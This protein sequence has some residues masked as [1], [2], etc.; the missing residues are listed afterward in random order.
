M[1][2]SMKTLAVLTLAM[3]LLLTGCDALDYRDAIALYNA[4]EFSQAADRFAQIPDYED[5]AQLYTRAR[6]WQALELY[7]AGQFT[8][9]AEVFAPL[10][11]YED[12][13]QLH[14]RCYYNLAVQTM[15]AGDYTDA[16][17]Q[18]ESL[19]GFEDVVQRIAECQ[20]Q[21]AIVAFQAEDLPAAQDQFSALGDYRM[22][23]DYLRQIGW[24]RFFDWMVSAGEADGA[25]YT[26][27]T[28]EDGRTVSVTADTDAPNRLILKIEQSVDKGYT[29][30]DTLTIVLPREEA[31]PTFTGVSTFTMML[32]AEPI[33]TTQESIGRLELATC[34]AD[35]KLS[36]ESYIKTGTDNQGNAISS[37]TPGD[38]TMYD[39]MNENFQVLM[40]TLP[41]LL[42]AH[43]APVSLAD[44]GF[45]Q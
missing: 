5:S 2:R 43:N 6:Y 20:Y 1:K 29:F 31:Y 28:Q 34:S 15:E 37:Q 8:E 14:T 17:T 4:G 33:G 25:A 23:R 26:L 45:P 10:G 7:N 30:S 3:L 32:G 36:V 41:Q 39:T 27:Q 35:T 38:S 44:L 21:L 12:S 22:S 18:F 40:T 16:I 19:D 9:A 11:N 42:E 13:K 24:Q